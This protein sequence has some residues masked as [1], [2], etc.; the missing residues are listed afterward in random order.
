MNTLEEIINIL[1]DKSQKVEINPRG[2]FADGC[3]YPCQE[4]F[5][6][7]NKICGPSKKYPFSFLKH[8][9]SKKFITR[10]L[11]YCKPPTVEEA[12]KIYVNGN[13]KVYS[14]IESYILKD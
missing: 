6:F 10:L 14:N 1:Y 13:V 12:V 5:P 3:W 2:H 11:T 7:S 4:F 9:R 8:C